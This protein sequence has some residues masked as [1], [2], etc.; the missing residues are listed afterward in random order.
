MVVVSHHPVLLY[1]ANRLKCRERR[2]EAA[3]SIPSIKS[4]ARDRRN[5]LS[6]FYSEFAASASVAQM[7]N[8]VTK[9]TREQETKKPNLLKSTLHALDMHLPVSPASDE[10]RN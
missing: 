9:S 8:A 3:A 10:R 4:A 1:S 7:P 2:W 5:W 6:S